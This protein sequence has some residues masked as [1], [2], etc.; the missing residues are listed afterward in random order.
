MQV[1]VFQ[2]VPF[3]GLGSIGVWLEERGASV[4][5]TRFFA[6]DSM[7]CVDDIDMLVVMGGPMSVNDHAAFPWLGVEKRFIGEAI[8]RNIPVLGVCLGAQLIANVLGARVY[9]NVVKEIGWFPIQ[10][11]STPDGVFSFP[12]E[13]LVCHWHGETFDLPEGAVRLARSEACENQAFQFKRHVIGLQFHLETTP[14][15]M[16][17]LVENC[18]QELVPGA[19]VQTA[20]ELR[21]IPVTRYRAINGLM[22]DVLT[23]LV[24]PRTSGALHC[25]AEAR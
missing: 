25:T 6:D 3:E 23:Y 10:A 15:S 11:V 9:S 24:E 4:S 5:S 7:P 12:S 2:H 22:S 13:C 18:R 20:Q 17:A 19:Y 16:R 14:E 21:A 8:A 1:H